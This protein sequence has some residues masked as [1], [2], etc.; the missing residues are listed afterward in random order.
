MKEETPWLS[1]FVGSNPTP[2]N[3]IQIQYKLQY[4]LKKFISIEQAMIIMAEAEKKRG[5]LLTAW[6]ILML[7]ANAGTTV[8]YFLAG[9]LITTLLP[10]IPSW[11]PYVLGVMSL[12]NFVFTI[13]LFKWKKWAFFAFCGMAGI[14]LVINIVIGT[15]ISSLFGL[16]GPVILYLLLRSKWNYLE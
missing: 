1:A 2:R 9:S 12:L 15:G 7:I 13:F 4:I 14:A 16:L 11:A 8:F 6:L 5:G 3:V 10:T